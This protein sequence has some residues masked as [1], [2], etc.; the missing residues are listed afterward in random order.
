METRELPAPPSFPELYARSVLR[1]PGRR[2]DF[3][4]TRVVLR[5]QRFD[6]DRL[7]EFCRLTGFPVRDEALHDLRHRYDELC[8]RKPFLP[9]EFNLRLPD[10]LVLDDVLAELPLD[11][12]GQKTHRRLGG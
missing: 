3:P 11:F 8:T 1:R 2:L 10:G 4:R 7:T 6:V 9:Y 5:D 12:F